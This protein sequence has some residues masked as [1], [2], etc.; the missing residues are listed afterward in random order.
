MHEG[1]YVHQKQN[2][3]IWHKNFTLLLFIEKE[4]D[5]NKFCLI[6]LKVLQ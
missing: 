5:W 1:V 3:L 2:E 6:Y 4:E